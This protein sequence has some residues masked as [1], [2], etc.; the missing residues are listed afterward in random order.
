MEKTMQFNNNCFEF[1]GFDILIDKNLKAWL[2][3]VNLA[4]SLG[5]SSKLDLDIKSNLV[6]DL[7]NMVGIHPKLS[8]KAEKHTCNGLLS[9]Y[10]KHGS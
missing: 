3:E 2:I 7:L 10:T 5:C 9:M 6:K 1:Y 4:P 8:K